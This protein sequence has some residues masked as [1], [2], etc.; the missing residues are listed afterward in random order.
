VTSQVEF[1]LYRVSRDDS[2]DTEK[3]IWTYLEDYLHRDP[4]IELK[5]AF[6]FS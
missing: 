5:S 1:G 3:R 6:G 4:A 2:V